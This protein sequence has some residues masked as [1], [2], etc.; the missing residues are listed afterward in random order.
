M[1]ATDIAPGP[2]DRLL[3]VRDRAG[4]AVLVAD[5]LAEH[6]RLDLLFNNAGIGPG[7]RTHELEPAVWDAVLDINLG[8][9]VNGVLAAWPVFVRQRS[10]H[11]V[12]T[13]SAA[14]LVPPPMVAAYATSKGGVVALSQSLRAEGASLGVRVSALCPGA[15]DTPI[16]D[17]A[18][19]GGTP[20]PSGPTLTGRQFMGLVGMKPIPP[21]RLAAIALEGVARTDSTA[22]PPRRCHVQRRTAPWLR[23]PPRVRLPYPRRALRGQGRE[24]AGAPQDRALLLPPQR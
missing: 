18:G 15:V 13:A 12:N 1:V 16:L 3:D 21:D 20:P 5:V 11:L 7:G 22:T 2:G 19:T 10:G 4:F 9:V 14:G 23:P 24:L 8:G 17:E 6:G